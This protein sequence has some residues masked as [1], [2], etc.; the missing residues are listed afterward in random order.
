MPRET[1]GKKVISKPAC[2][3]KMDFFDKLTPSH[4]IGR[5]NLFYITEKHRVAKTR[6]FG[7][8]G[9]IRTTEAKTQQIYSLPPLA[10][11]EHAHIY[12]VRKWSWW[13]DLN[14]RPADYKSAALPTELHQH[15]IRYSVSVPLTTSILYHTNP[16]LSSTFSKKF[17]F[18]SIFFE[19][20][21]KTA[22]LC[23]FAGEW[24][25]TDTG[26]T[27]ARARDLSWNRGRSTGCSP[28]TGRKALRGFRASAR[29]C[30][31]SRPFCRRLPRK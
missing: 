9:W 12:I 26:Y 22:L 25:L 2:A 3:G 6:C 11:R 8:R 18:S 19:N 30:P 1:R 10:T 15:L 20:P 24:L 5:A 7:G 21:A 27:C 31:S 13:T 17:S 28:R 14:P 16:D 4:N 29:R 23:G